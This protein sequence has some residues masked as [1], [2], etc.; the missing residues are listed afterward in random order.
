MAPNKFNHLTMATFTKN[1]PLEINIPC[2]KCQSLVILHVV[3]YYVNIPQF[4]YP[5]T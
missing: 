1:D 5:L 4:S 3:F 2:C